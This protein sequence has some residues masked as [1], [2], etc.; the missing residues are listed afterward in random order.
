M[1][2]SF[3]LGAAM[4]VAV[5]ALAHVGRVNSRAGKGEHLALFQRL[6]HCEIAAPDVFL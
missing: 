3:L 5:P 1:L 2:K 4:V 6:N